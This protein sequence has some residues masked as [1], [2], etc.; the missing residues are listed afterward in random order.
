MLSAPKPVSS[1]FG[2]GEF[3]EIR[4]YE[5]IYLTI[6]HTVHIGC[7][8]VGAMIFHTAVIKDVTAYL[9]T[10]FDFLF[11]CLNFCLLLHAVLQLL[12]IKD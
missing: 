7:L 6:H 2:T 8:I 9:A 10:P 4:L 1:G 3:H 5:L 12:V 11:A